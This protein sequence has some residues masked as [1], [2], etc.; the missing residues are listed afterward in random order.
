M[1]QEKKIIALIPI[2]EHSERVHGKN[3][4]QFCGKPLYHHIV[5]TLNNCDAVDE[6]VI[7]TDS[8]RIIQEA[9]GLSPKVQVLLRPEKLRG[10]YVSTNRIFAYDL[11]QTQADI[12]LQTHAT[13]PLLQKKTIEKA[14]MTFLELRDSYDSLFSVNCYQNR[15]FTAE[16]QPI[17]HD[18]NEMLR[19]QDLPA[20][21]EENSCLYIFTKASFQ[22]T[23]SRI[24]KN[25][26]M[27]VTPF[28]E[29]VDIDEPEDWE[30][31]EILYMRRVGK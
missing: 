8:D 22:K 24:G 16:G 31:A 5:G 14:L 4:R 10:D 19:T 2:K 3:C 17:N 30:I 26:Y 25:P 13:N 20:L 1:I 6:I 9:V 28:L 21:Y 11:E 7:N 18:P 15:F 23:E 27:F 29:S 12:Y